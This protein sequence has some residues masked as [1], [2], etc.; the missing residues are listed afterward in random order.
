LSIADGIATEDGDIF[1]I[2]AKPFGAALRNPLKAMRP[3]FKPGGVKT[4]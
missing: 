1:E 3:T 4:L 2:E